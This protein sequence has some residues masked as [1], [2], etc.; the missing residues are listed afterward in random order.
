MKVYTC[1]NILN[2]FDKWR[3]TPDWLLTQAPTQDLS[4][5]YWLW[6][7][8]SD[9]LPQTWSVRIRQDVLRR[10]W[11]SDRLLPASLSAYLLRSILHLHSH[12]ST[13]KH[14]SDRMCRIPPS[15]AKH[16]GRFVMMG[17]NRFWMLLILFMFYWVLRWCVI[18]RTEKKKWT[19][20]S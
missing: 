8:R 18:Y 12:R 10:R 14:S 17:S 3:R 16:H 6:Q 4:T 11:V 1:T 15:I 9:S 19:S 7:S 13:H 2:A 20:Q 5:E